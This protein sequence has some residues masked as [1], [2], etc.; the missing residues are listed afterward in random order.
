MNPHIS[1]I[2]EVSGISKLVSTRHRTSFVSSFSIL[3]SL[4]VIAPDAKAD[5]TAFC[6]SFFLAISPQ[7]KFP[8]RKF[9]KERP[10]GNFRTRAGKISVKIY[11][12]PK[13]KTSCLSVAPLA[14]THI[15]TMNENSKRNVGATISFKKGGNFFHFH[16]PLYFL[17][18]YFSSASES[19]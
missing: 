5:L 2:Y 8:C 1:L 11:T 13:N 12:H 15:A 6:K 18:L 7:E 4:F 16:T 19:R 9:G 3:I 17:F 14:F 10:N